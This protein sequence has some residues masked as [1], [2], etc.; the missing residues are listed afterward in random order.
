MDQRRRSPESSYSEKPIKSRTA[1]HAIP[2]NGIQSMHKIR[3]V[4]TNVVE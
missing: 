2:D 4:R 1:S 3:A